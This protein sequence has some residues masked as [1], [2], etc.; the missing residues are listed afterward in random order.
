LFEFGY[1]SVYRGENLDSIHPAI[2]IAP[3]KLIPS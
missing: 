3:F 1:L 2:V